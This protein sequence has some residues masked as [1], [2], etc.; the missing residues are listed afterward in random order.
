VRRAVL[1]VIAGFL[2]VLLGLG[3]F[4]YIRMAPFARTE[5]ADL[6]PGL[7]AILGGGGNSVVLVDGAGKK[8]LV[9]DTKMWPTAR[10]VL[11]A[12]RAAGAEPAVVINTHYHVDHTHGNPEYP[13]GTRV[14]ASQKSLDHL[15]SFDRAFWDEEPAK[16]LLPNEPLT[17]P[18]VVSFGGETVEVVPLP[19]A[20]T[21]GD[22][23]VVFRNARVAAAG[24]VFIN[25]MYPRIDRR[26]GGSWRSALQAFD[27][28]LALPA[29][30]FV[31]GHGPAGDRAAVE[32]SRAF[33]AALVDET[34][35]IASGGG[36]LDDALAQVDLARFGLVPTGFFTSRNDCIRTA[37]EELANVK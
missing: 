5:R 12:V 34:A 28:L 26:G 11:D 33:V 32:K 1:I 35:R 29:D 36:T 27:A 24:D 25:G 23:A 17:A 9:V 22:V 4:V 14:V 8:A 30:R 15:L 10:G 6:A 20:H 2:L 19:R 7:F 16:S 13:K 37:W 31:P 18:R 21:D 3:S